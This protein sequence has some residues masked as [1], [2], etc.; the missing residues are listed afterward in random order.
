M[1]KNIGKAVLWIMLYSFASTIGILIAMGGAIASNWTTF[2]EMVNMSSDDFMEIWLD[3]ILEAMIPGTCIAGILCII[4]FCVY[5]LISKQKI[6]LFEVQP[7]KAVFCLSLGAVFNLI[8]TYVLDFVWEYLPESIADS[9]AEATEGL[10]TN[11][12]HWSFMLLAVGIIVPIA[13]EIIFRHGICRSVAKSNTKV[14]VILSAIVFGLAHGNVVQGV[15]TAIMGVFCAFVMLNSNNLWYAIF[16]HIGLNSTS[17][18]STSITDENLSNI[19]FL[20]MGFAGLLAVCTMLIHKP[21]I[22]ALLKRPSLAVAVSE[23]IPVCAETTQNVE[24][25]GI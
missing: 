10:I 5:K 8:I 22:R 16:I 6:E 3:I 12:F 4:G 15:Y 11:S 21:E 17:V 2:S 18:I 24:S 19:I 14:A 7:S 13:E 1:I 25:H 23:P 9:A 20:G